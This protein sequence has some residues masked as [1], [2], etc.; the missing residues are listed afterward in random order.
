MLQCE[1]ILLL[2]D[3]YVIKFTTATPIS[4]LISQKL[5]FL[6][7]SL[8]MSSLPTFALKSPN[9]IFVYYYDGFAQSIKL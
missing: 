6:S 4:L 8:K 5:S 3:F 1:N 9:S 2:T 7:V